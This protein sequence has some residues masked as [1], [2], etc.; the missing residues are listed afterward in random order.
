MTDDVERV[1]TIVIGGG[2]AG[3]S[4]GHHLA[5]RGIS[6]LILDANERIGD[7]W[8]QRWESLR[9]FTSA[10]YDGLDGM[11]FPARKNSFPTKDD[12]ADY[13]EAYAAQFALPVRNSTRVDA[14]RRE[15]ARYVVM[16]GD[17]RFEAEHVVV[18][19]ANFQAKREPPFRNELDPGIR[20]IHSSEYRNL[21]QLHAGGA[22]VVGAGNSGAEIALELARGGVPACLSGRDV[23]HVPYRVDSLA[24]HLVFAPVVLRLVFHRLLSTSTP[25]GRKARGNSIAHGAPLIRVKPKDLAAAGVVRVPRVAGVRDGKPVL[26]DGRVMDVR[27]VIWCTGFRSAFSWVDRPVFDERGQPRH[28]R[29]VVTGEPGLYFLGLHFLHAFSSVMVHGVGRDAEYVANVIGG[30]LRRS[31][32]SRSDSPREELVAISA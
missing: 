27:N 2:Q 14:V 15:G 9:L 13:L 4:V 32:Q 21:S 28:E 30:R 1:Q 12:M 31:A 10:R 26:D 5:N 20:Q 22:L 19:M 16:A 29:G 25:M 18:A 24:A 17:R 11:P 7:A 6:F 23:G 8:R 3:L